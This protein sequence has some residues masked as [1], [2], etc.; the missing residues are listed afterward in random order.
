MSKRLLA[1]ALVL[2]MVFSAL[3]ITLAAEADQST[4]AIHYFKNPDYTAKPMARMWFPDATAGIDENDTIA[5]QINALAEAG[6]GGVEI[7]MLADSSTYTN[8]QT[9]YCGWGTE[10]WVELLKK[11]YRAANDVEGGFVVD[12]T[13]SAH[14]PPSI[15][16]IDPND[17]AASQ[18][19]STSMTKITAQAIQDGTLK[20][21]LPVQ[22][23][24]D[25]RGANFLFV[26][27]LVNAVVVKVDSVEKKIYTS[28]GGCSG[29]PVVEEEYDFYNLDFST[30]QAITVEATEDGYAAGVPDAAAC[31]AHGWDYED[32][33]EAFGP[34]PAEDAILE[35]TKQDAEGNR[36]RMADWQNYYAADVH[37]LELSV[38]D[39]EAIEDGDW[40][41]LGVFTRGTGQNM[42]G[43]G[44]T[45]MYNR[46][47]VMN[48]FD[49]SGIKAV[50]DYWDAHI[51]CDEELA[52]MI[53]ENGGSIFEDS[54]ETSVTTS[55]WASDMM[56]EIV[57]YYGTEYA[58]T[59]ILPAVVGGF[60][61][62]SSF[63]SSPGKDLYDFV[64]AE[65]DGVNLED[66]I[67]ED[68]N[69]LAGYLYNT[70]HLEP[71]NEW[72][73]SIG[74]TYRSQTYDLTGMDIAG[75]A[76][77]VQIPEGD[78]M[79]KG[80]G[81]RQLAA[82]ANLYDKKYLSMEAIT[83]Q[84]Q[85]QFNWETVLY[86]LTANFS[87]GVNRAVF[88]GT[89][90]SK[91]INGK[92]ADWPGWDQFAGSFGEAYSYRQVYWNEMNMLTDYVA[93]SQALLQYTNQTIDVAIVRDATEAFENPSGN[94]FQ[95]VLDHGYS[96]NIMS[97]ALLL[98][99]NAQ[100][101]SNG[102]I[103][104]E[105]PGYRA[106]ILDDVH[107]MSCKAMDV[108]LNYAKAG[109]PIIAV[110][111]NP[112]TVYGTN[113]ANNSDA[114]VAQKYAE[115]LSYDCVST[116]LTRDEVPEAL[117]K[118]GVIAYA[119]YQIPSLETT[120][121]NDHVDGTSYYYMFNNN[122]TFA[123]MISGTSGKSYKDGTYGE[124]I[125][126][127]VVTL[128]G[129]GTPY[130]LDAMTGEIVQ[131][132]QY[133]V[134]DDG[135][136]TVLIDL[137]K[138]GNAVIVALSDNTE[139]FPAPEVHVEVADN[140]ENYQLLREADGSVT[141]RSSVAGTYR[142]TNSYGERVSATVDTTKEVVDLTDLEWNLVIDSYG[143]KYDNASEMVDERGIQTVD[144][145]ETLITTHD[146]GTVTLKDWAEL[147]A[148]E[149]VLKKLGVRSMSEVSGKG[150]YTATFEWDGSDAALWISY[151]NDQYTG[152]T[153]NGK[154]IDALNNMTDVVDLGGYLVEGENT[155]VIELST[156][157]ADRA[158]VENDAYNQ[159][160]TTVN[161]LLKAMLR[162]Y[163]DVTLCTAR[164][165]ATIALHGSEN[166]T[167]GQ[168][169][170]YTV[171]V[172]DTENLAT[173]TVSIQLDGQL[174]EPTV[175][176]QSGWFLIA[177]DYVDGVLTVVVAN[178]T[179]VTT[180]EAS[181][182]FTVYVTATKAG[183]VTAS[184]MDATL[185]AY[186]QSSET[187][188]DVLIG[189]RDVVTAFDYS[190]Y[191][192]NQDGT[193]DQLDITR[194]QRAYGAV[195]GDDNWNARADVDGNGMV[196]IAD[197][198]LILNHYSK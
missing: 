10:A 176:M 41:V 161:G 44:E 144:P 133:T 134:N 5:K 106:I 1:L 61:G 79:T 9:K 130:L 73:S 20:L 65:V 89:A 154:K 32:T 57:S 72:A 38:N 191:D 15:N 68:Y 74:C 109:I 104:E 160:S 163:T 174:E 102:K 165:N 190:I 171:S 94:S 159:G 164:P 135:T 187:F 112:T 139:D 8:E 49:E 98:G 197:L 111:S 108:L 150:Y 48:Y 27:R 146:F 40:V 148:S 172:A 14:W 122:S 152:L 147:E 128:T 101:I 24:E 158:Y 131:A 26:D 115:L 138:A 162:P 170:A 125:T 60:R 198:I 29:G 42:S 153:V 55:L 39:T 45:L 54:I 67:Q 88:H 64:K 107:T 95:A 173:A 21:N 168:S 6:F 97:E 63:G 110:N 83:G 82:A 123:G 99:E 114:Q 192:V 66:R 90:Y 16:T 87:W 50:T 18:E 56:D 81:L 36:Q 58:Y 103:Y 71:A 91:S 78:N 140:G 35:G 127:A 47:Y 23:T 177:S 105:G 43:N 11:V 25:G 126:D 19:V 137:I 59:D 179:G 188:L 3:P 136:V 181:D 22:A 85:Y 13:I 70:Q 93:R 185:S 17:E 117:E 151:G 31:E 195:M 182:I 142:L 129:E 46:T 121:Y 166:A 51:L 4:S 143:P 28:G 196:D 37:A 62:G 116:V 119:Q 169:T 30:M 34:E 189:Q 124:D 118:Q 7:A 167:L 12:M 113:K 100:K 193:V 175:Q 194:A 84:K 184:L 80:D 77:V 69:T 155:I 86:E 156:T 178:Q 132:P 2:C 75:A 96:Y 120:R 183:T 149:D 76:S 157:L 53:R 52:A 180:Q 141:L 186:S 33:L 145:S 92:N